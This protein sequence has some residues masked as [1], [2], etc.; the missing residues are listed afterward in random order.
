ML[1]VQVRLSDY[2]DLRELVDLNPTPFD[3]SGVSSS[4]TAYILTVSLAFYLL[5]SPFKVFIPISWT[6]W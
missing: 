3:P 5:L 1:G 6:R 2:T 4:S